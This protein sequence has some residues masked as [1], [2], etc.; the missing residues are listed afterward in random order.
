MSH[1]ETIRSNSKTSDLFEGQVQ[2]LAIVAFMAMGACSALVRVADPSW[3]YVFNSMTWAKIAIGVAIVHQIMVA[4]VFRLQL[5]KNWMTNRFGERD[6]QV[7][8]GLFLPFLIARPITILITGLSDTTPITGIR[9]A[10]IIIG[11]VLIL[12]AVAGMHSVL[13]YFTI[14][15]A[16]G[17]DHFRDSYAKMP[18]VKEGIF[19]YTNNG[20][21]GVVFFGLTGLALVLGSW[22][23]LI[24]ALFQQAYIWVHMYCTEGPDMRRIYDPS[25]TVKTAD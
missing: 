17:G 14:P 7:W 15:R 10:E 2:H 24:A 19:K 18:L 3:V 5:H 25:L 21:Y 11:V 13:K 1:L 16:L 8:A 23:A 9:S 20:M 22:N 6:M 12:G 4:I